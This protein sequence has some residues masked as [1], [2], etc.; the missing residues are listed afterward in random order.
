MRLHCPNISAAP[1][2]PS[3]STL[4]PWRAPMLKPGPADTRQSGRKVS[5]QSTSC[6]KAFLVWIIGYNLYL[7]NE[8]II[9]KHGSLSDL[10]DKGPA[11]AP[12]PI[13]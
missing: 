4:Q 10:P 8:H 7:V 12:A 1:L 11:L 6:L 9:K 2:P 5:P 3:F 13:P